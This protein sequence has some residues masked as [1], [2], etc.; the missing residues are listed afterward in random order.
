M[1]AYRSFRNIFGVQA[2]KVLA[3]RDKISARSQSRTLQTEATGDSKTPVKFSPL[4]LRNWLITEALSQYDFSVYSK[5]HY[6][7][8]ETR[9]GIVVEN[10]L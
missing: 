2:R 5:L 4:R 8:A 6:G 3:K 7:L 9:N 10:C 1:C